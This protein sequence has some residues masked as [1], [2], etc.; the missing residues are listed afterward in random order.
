MV[1]IGV[2]YVIYS[3]MSKEVVI[4]DKI[5]V[6]CNGDDRK[7]SNHPKVWLKIKETEKFIDCP[8][9]ERRFLYEPSKD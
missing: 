3:V 7:G 2:K 1:A 9:C 5:V 4:T 6:S 8:Y